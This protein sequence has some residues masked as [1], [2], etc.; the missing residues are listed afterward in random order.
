VSTRESL[1]SVPA[2]PGVGSVA[3]T[4]PSSGAVGLWLLA[5]LAYGVG[6]VATTVAG[7][8]TPGVVETNP[9][10]RWAFANSVVGGMVALKGLAFAAAYLLWRAAPQAHR[11][12]VPLGLV[13]SGL[14]VTCW[15][16][17][18]LAASW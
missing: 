13:L 14:A 12:G 18:V 16:L 2:I 6:D 9:V 17:S 15:N 4:R 1:P 3:P 8:H 5:V 7:V 11:V 10:A